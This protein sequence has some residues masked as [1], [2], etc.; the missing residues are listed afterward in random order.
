MQLPLRL[1]KKVLKF[2][3]H[4]RYKRLIIFLF[5]ALSFAKFAPSAVNNS[6]FCASCHEMRPNYYTLQASS[7]SQL[8]CLN[9]H[10]KWDRPEIKDV[11]ELLQPNK[12]RQIAK[13]LMDV[14][15]EIVRHFI[16]NKDIPIISMNPPEDKV[17]LKCHTLHRNVTPTGDLIIPHERHEPK[18]VTCVTCHAEVVHGQTSSSDYTEDKKITLW[19]NTDLVRKTFFRASASPPM[20]VCMTCHKRRRV[21]L[22]CNA[23]HTNSKMPPTHQNG[24]FIQDHGK[25]ARKDLNVCNECHQ[26]AA[27]SYI[28]KNIDVVSYT[29]ENPFCGGCHGKMPP[30]HMQESWKS[31]HGKNKELNS[32]ST[33]HPQK[34]GQPGIARISCEQCHS[35]KHGADWRRMHPIEVGKGLQGKCFECHSKSTCSSCHMGFQ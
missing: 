27:D 11:K 5:I 13:P 23:C 1:A 3:I 28:R 19:E 33:C 8:S 4:T 12:L 30:S 7:H 15:S 31:D 34:A 18:K 29:R 24:N 26:Y 35:Q 25:L 2:F 20:G 22:E 17:C 14:E 32:C 10:W 6:R 9:C 16:R 21:T